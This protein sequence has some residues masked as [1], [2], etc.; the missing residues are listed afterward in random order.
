MFF[1]GEELLESLG[2]DLDAAGINH[3]ILEAILAAALIGSL[4]LTA[5]EIRSLQMREQ[6]MKS[7]LQV[8][9]G[10]FAR[11]LDEH[12]DEWSLTPSERDVAL[13]AIKGLTIADIARIRETK[14]GTIKAQCNAIY[15]KAGVT[16]RTQLLSIFIEEL[17][18]ED[19]LPSQTIAKAELWRD[20]Q[21]GRHRSWNR[22]T[23]VA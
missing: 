8:A 15:R 17:L 14:E 23:A 11:L 12:F 9:T 2:V 13:L 5:V 22:I 16:G 7:Q 6:R 18:A 10:A 3:D 4:L 20:N 19:L 1:L 21:F